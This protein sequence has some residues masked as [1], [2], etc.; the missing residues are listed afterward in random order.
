M[1][2]VKADQTDTSFAFLT[3]GLL[4]FVAYLIG[5]V[6]NLSI[7]LG[8]IMICDYFTGMTSALYLG[9]FSLNLAYKG[10]LKKTGALAFI[11]VSAQVDIIAGQGTGFLR[12][13]MIFT[14]IGLEGVSVLENGKKLGYTVPEWLNNIFYSFAKKIPENL[15]P[16]TNVTQQPPEPV[17][18]NDEGD[19]MKS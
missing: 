7:C 14:L 17:N 13:A 6:D 4:S 1:G 15:P 12:D 3:G 18:K 11:V 9:N 8:V 5:G 19:G 2:K 10:M 16:T